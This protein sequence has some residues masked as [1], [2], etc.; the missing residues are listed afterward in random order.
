MQLTGPLTASS[1]S[2][3]PLTFLHIPH[4]RSQKEFLAARCRVYPSPQ[5]RV[6]IVL[7]YSDHLW[8]HYE[9]LL[10]IDKLR[11]LR[12]C[13]ATTIFSCLFQLSFMLSVIVA[14]YDITHAGSQST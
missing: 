5:P 14:Q 1:Y 10:V 3:I 4:R 2:C 13:L 12:I 6:D 11:R 7:S 9:S 8:F